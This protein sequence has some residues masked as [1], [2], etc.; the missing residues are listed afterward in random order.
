MTAPMQMETIAVGGPW[1]EDFVIGETLPT[2][3]AV[4]LTE[5]HAAL[6]QAVFGDRLRLPL[7]HTLSREVTGASTA[8]VHPMLA[9]NLAIGMSTYATQRVKANLFYRGLVL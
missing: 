8:L 9:I 1:F 3:P 2:S 5:G 4:T 7:D 6:H